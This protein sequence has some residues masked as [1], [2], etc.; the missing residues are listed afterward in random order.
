MRLVWLDRSGQDWKISSNNHAIIAYIIAWQQY[1]TSETQ[2]LG[3]TVQQD[4]L[5][6][7]YQFPGNSNTPAAPIPVP[8]HMET[9]PYDL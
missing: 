2:Q 3:K 1:I 4:R 7:F 6:P 9:T 8:M 5:S